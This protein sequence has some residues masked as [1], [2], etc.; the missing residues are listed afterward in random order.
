MQFVY[1]PIFFTSFRMTKTVFGVLTEEK[2]QTLYALVREVF[3]VPI[4][5]RTLGLQQDMFLFKRWL[6]KKTCQSWSAYL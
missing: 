6:K 1:Q 2:F 5:K 3:K 4:N